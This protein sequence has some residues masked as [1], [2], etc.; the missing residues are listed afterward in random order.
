MQLQLLNPEAFN[1]G[2]PGNIKLGSLIEMSIGVAVGAI[3]FS[4][5][6]IAFLKVAGI[7]SGSPITFKG[8]HPLNAIILVSIIVLTYLL[9]STQSSNLF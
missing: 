4:G 6:V 9:C 8:Q 3:T 7:M 1:L 5:S 2:N